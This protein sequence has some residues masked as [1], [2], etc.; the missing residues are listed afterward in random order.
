M[1]FFDIQVA[2]AAAQAATQAVQSAVPHGSTQLQTQLGAAAASAYII[3]LLQKVKQLPW[4][5]AHSTGINRGIRLFFSFIAAIGVDAK[6]NSVEHS[7][8]I[9][10]LSLT[11]VLMAGWHWFQQYAFTHMSGGLINMASG[12]PNG[13][14]PQQPQQ[15]SVPAPAVPAF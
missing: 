8:L 3:I 13:V 1:L 2:Q 9:T 5:T 4:I 15:P 6:W 10:G 14:L 7:L 12:K 11:A